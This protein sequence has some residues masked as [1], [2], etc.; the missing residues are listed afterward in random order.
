MIIPWLAPLAVVGLF[1]IKQSTSRFEWVVIAVA[2]VAMTASLSVMSLRAN[3]E[4]RRFVGDVAAFIGQVRDDA[5]SDP[6]VLSTLSGDGTPRTLWQ[7]SSTSQPLLTSGSLIDL[8]LLLDTMPA[9]VT[10]LQVLTE[11]PSR[12]Q[13]GG[14]ISRTR[15]SRWNIVSSTQ[16]D[17]TGFFAYAL[18]RK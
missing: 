16:S 14:M 4:W 6:V 2:V 17:N 15:R 12:E 8:K 7:L 18:E 13:F 11:I 5:P 1:A 9:K 3:A 10:G